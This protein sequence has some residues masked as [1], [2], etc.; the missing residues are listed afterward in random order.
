MTKN[1]RF[2]KC[3]V[4]KISDLKYIRIQNWFS[5]C[6]VSNMS[7]KLNCNL[8]LFR[9]TWQKIDH[10]FYQVDSHRILEIRLRWNSLTQDGERQM[11]NLYSVLWKIPIKDFWKLK[12][13]F[14]RKLMSYA[15]QKRSNIAWA[16]MICLVVSH[17][18]WSFSIKI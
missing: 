17:F 3:Q 12:W 10:R 11:K 6:Q 14:F 7:E 9:Y 15:S 2:Q 8:M 5:K 1:V 4:W 18:P 16:H 13:G